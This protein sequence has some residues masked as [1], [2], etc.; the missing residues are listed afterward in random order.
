MIFI[1]VST[2]DAC[3]AGLHYSSCYELCVDLGPVHSLLRLLLP[4]GV[5]AASLDG[6]VC[7]F[8]SLAMGR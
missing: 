2:F 8:R 6:F 5:N 7:L 1:D 4:D 3:L